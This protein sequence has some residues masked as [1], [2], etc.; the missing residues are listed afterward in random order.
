[1]TLF[2]LFLGLLIG[3]LLLIVVLYFS[4]SPQAVTGVAHESFSTMLHSGESVAT[5]P[6]VKWIA[7][8]FGLCILSIFVVSIMIGYRK[9][10]KL[11]KVKPWLIGGSIA[12]L[13]VFSMMVFSYWHY[14]EEGSAAYFLGFPA[15]TAWM[16]YAVWLFPLFFSFIYIFKFNDWVISPEER[17]RFEE[18]KK[19]SERVR[20]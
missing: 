4:P 1:M 3:L 9:Y 14:V 10:E 8:F 17:K 20:R 7:F 16:L 11:G 2:K 5:A 13:L 6:F 18:I 19:R 15:P 12:Y